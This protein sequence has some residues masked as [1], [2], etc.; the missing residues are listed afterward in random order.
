MVTKWAESPES[1]DRNLTRGTS[2]LPNVQ[3]AV[4]V[5]TIA[6]KGKIVFPS[7]KQ[8]AAKLFMAVTT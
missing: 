1:K 5:R 2:S 4:V 6:R 8:K 3:L 7:V